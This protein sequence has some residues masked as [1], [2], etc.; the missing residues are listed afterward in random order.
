MKKT[1]SPPPAKSAAAST[2]RPRAGGEEEA[3]ARERLAQARAQ[4]AVHLAHIHQ[5]DCEWQGEGKE[6]LFFPVTV[7]DGRT[8]WRMS[9]KLCQKQSD[10]LGFAEIQDK[11]TQAGAV[12]LLLAVARC[13]IG[14]ADDLQDNPVQWAEAL[15]AFTGF[16]LPFAKRFQALDG[17]NEEECK[18][19]KKDAGEWVES[20]IENAFPHVFQ[21]RS[22]QRESAQ[23]ID[24]AC[25]LCNKNNRLPSKQEVKIASPWWG[26]REENTWWK[27]F[28]AAGL[29]DL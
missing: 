16:L 8:V 14:K 22:V 24:I 15:P 5:A 1:S 19:I 6:P 4:Q 27:R 29:G 28:K 17:A 3:A 25:L 7:P 20:I 13:Q 18:K 2:S 12:A 26:G 21:S 9:A 11:E 10:L 23:L